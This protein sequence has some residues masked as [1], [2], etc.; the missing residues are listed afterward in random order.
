MKR[1]ENDKN[2]SSTKKQCV[3][4]INVTNQLNIASNQCDY[5]TINTRSEDNIQSVDKNLSSS[6]V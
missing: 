4:N 2:N 3:E 5:S 1:K 6:K